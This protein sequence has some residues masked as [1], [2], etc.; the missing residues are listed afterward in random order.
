MNVDDWS[1]TVRV[2]RGGDVLLER[3]AGP[4]GAH[5]PVVPTT[6]FQAG[7]ISKQLVAVAVLQLVD[8]RALTLHDPIDRWLD[9]LPATWRELTLH[10]LLIHTSGLGPWGEV[11]G[12]DLGS[13]QRI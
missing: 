4:A 6:R 10:Q 7:S 8:Q 3:S 2:V 1:G 9:G 11:P 13:P 12:L 5:G